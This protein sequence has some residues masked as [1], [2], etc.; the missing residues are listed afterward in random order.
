M[1]NLILLF[2][3]VGCLFTTQAQEKKNKNAKYNVEVKGNCDMCKKRIEKAALGVK[4]VKSAQWQSEEQ[5]LHLI[6]NEEKTSVTD[7]ENA[8]ANAGHDTQNVKATT[9]DY[10]NLHGCCQ[11]SRE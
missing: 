10:G 6:L 11:Y 9:E 2:L 1:K 7:V 3:T 4:G 5:K 8:V